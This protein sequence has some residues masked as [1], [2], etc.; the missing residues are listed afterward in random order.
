M[1][2]A[3]QAHPEKL[4]HPR[5]QVEVGDPASHVE[6]FQAEERHHMADDDPDQEDLSR[7]AQG[8]AGSELGGQGKLGPAAASLRRWTIS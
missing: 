2:A 3:L 8:R 6:Q 7:D 5:R 4:P 1:D